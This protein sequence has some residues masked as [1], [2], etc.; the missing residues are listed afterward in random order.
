MV[1]AEPGWLHAAGQAAGTILLLEL[2]LLLFIMLALM[3]GLAFGAWWIR[4]R[5]VPVV[6]EY[7]P[8][9]KQV[10]TTAQQGSDRVVHGVAEFYGRRQ[11]VE[12][13]LRV[14]LFGNRAA[15]RYH[16]EELVHAATDLTMMTPMDDSGPRDEQGQVVDG[17]HFL[18]E[19]IN[20]EHPS[21]ISNGH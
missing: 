16:D 4:K 2:G 1:I 3:A 7:A 17:T 9:A 13:S 15:T 14:L 21:A 11:Q 19:Q 6:A 8:K 20:S 5:V 10:M 18:Q 12:T